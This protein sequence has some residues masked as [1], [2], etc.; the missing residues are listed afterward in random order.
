MRTKTIKNKNNLALRVFLSM[1]EN[2]WELLFASL[3]FLK[4]KMFLFCC[5][6]TLHVNK[7]HCKQ[8]VYYFQFFTSEF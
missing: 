2:K 1:I 5:Y 4:M 7:R 8:S 3:G 6:F